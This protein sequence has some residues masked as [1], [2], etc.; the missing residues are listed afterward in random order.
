MPA[1]APLLEDAER[2]CANGECQKAIGLFENTLARQPHDFRL[3]YRLGLCYGGDCRPHPLVHADMAVAYLRQALHLI[4]AIPGRVR[5]S[6]V[7]QLGNALCHQG[8]APRTNALRAAIECHREA[9]EI[10]QSL[11]MA[12][13]CGRARFNVGN[14]CCELSEITGEDHWQE[15]V[16]HYR[17]SLRVR[18]REKDPERHA[19]VLENLGSAYRRLPS[20]RKSIQCY[21]QALRI[22]TAAAHPEKSAA[23][24]N[25]LGN[26]YLSL[27]SA[28]TKT[29][30]RNALRA[31]RHFDRALRIQGRDKTSRA[32][33]VTQFNR[34]QAYHR[35]AQTAVEIA[36]LQ[37]ALSAFQ[38][39]GEE[40]LTGLVR[41]QLDLLYRP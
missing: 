1:G 38:A 6:V 20:A 4:G 2:A 34:A 7:D 22:Y 16:L 8:G 5:A 32:F 25:N 40:R 30:F 24:E 36:C 12:D 39:C 14:S 37:E 9:A 41:A 17:E 23:L 29:K 31:L 3:H 15:A 10:Y 11:G 33:G 13:D 18:T 21:Q 35:L 28:D 27:P 26:A 19:A